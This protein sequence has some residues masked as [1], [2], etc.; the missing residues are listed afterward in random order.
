MVFQ[1]FSSRN[2]F[3]SPLKNPANGAWTPSEHPSWDIELRT[4][5]STFANVS[6]LEINFQEHVLRDDLTPPGNLS[7]N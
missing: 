6:K 1:H 2:I 3:P 4:C 7:I 5:R